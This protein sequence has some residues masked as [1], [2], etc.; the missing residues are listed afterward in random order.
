MKKL[1][2]CTLAIICVFAAYGN[3]LNDTVTVYFTLSRSNYEP[4]LDNNAVSVDS[5]IEQLS[6]GIA[7]HSLQNVIVT[8]YASPEGPVEFNKKLA[9][10]RRQ[11]LIDI[12]IN[13]TTISQQQVF[14]QQPEKGEEWEILRTLVA[15]TP[16]VP[17]RDK[18]IAIINA[19]NLTDAQRLLRIKAIDNRTT[20][21]WLL[22]HIFP[23]LRFA[24]AI[25]ILRKPAPTPAPIEPAPAVE[26]V[27]ADSIADGNI[28]ATMDSV[29]TT[30]DSIED[31]IA[32]TVD[33][34]AAI[35]V[36]SYCPRH[37]LALKTNMLYYPAMIPNLELEYLFLDNWSAAIEGNVAWWWKNSTSKSYRLAIFD[38]EMRYWI[39]PRAPWH[40]FYAGVFAGGGLYD[41]ENGG[42]GY[43]GEGVMA[44]IS[45]GFMWPIKRN[46]SLEAGIGGGYLYTRAKEYKPYEGHFV[47]QRTK[48]YNY[49]GPL[50]LKFSLVWRFLDKNK[51]NCPQPQI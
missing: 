49:F 32:A 45:C 1:I 11:A 28:S 15:N 41:L 21:R 44:G 2:A 18:I 23:K 5:F 4:M 22:K 6:A 34:I 17:N 24:R 25:A 27:T 39:K 48:A 14:T 13:R 20:Y 40:G 50:K 38:A 26:I 19:D 36:D 46:L 8:G 9:N 7:S 29:V 3:T 16:N 43:Q 35:P 10:K 51:I 37:L 47:Y 30:I 12:I 31:S 42:N 33:S